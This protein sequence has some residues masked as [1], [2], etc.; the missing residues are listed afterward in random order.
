[1][2]AAQNTRASSGCTAAEPDI[3]ARMRP[4]N[5][6]LQRANTS[7][8]ATLSAA[9]QCQSAVYAKPFVANASLQGKNS[10]T[11]YD[12]DRAPVERIKIRIME[13]ALGLFLFAALVAFCCFG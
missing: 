8:S 10:P 4:P 3:I 6:S 2:R 12:L 9:P 5:A 1:M 11:P 7:Q 13:I